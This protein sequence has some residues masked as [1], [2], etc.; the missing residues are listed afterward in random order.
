MISIISISSGVPTIYIPLF[1]VLGVTAVK[2]YMEDYKRKK[3]DRTENFS[4]C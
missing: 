4:K 2:D 1:V 3:S